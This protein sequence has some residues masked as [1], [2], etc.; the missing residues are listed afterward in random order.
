MP[1]AVVCEVARWYGVAH[2]LLFTW[3]RQARMAEPNGQEGSILT[4]GLDRS[5]DGKWTVSEARGD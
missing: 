4:S 3:R 2:N 1:R 5:G